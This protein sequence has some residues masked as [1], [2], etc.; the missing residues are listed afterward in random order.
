MPCWKHLSDSS[1]HGHRGYLWIQGHAC[2]C[3]CDWLHF[4]LQAN[5]CLP[6]ITEIS[7]SPLLFTQVPF[8]SPQPA[9]TKYFVQLGLSAFVLLVLTQIQAASHMQSTLCLL[10]PYSSTGPDVYFSTSTYPES[11]QCHLC[12]KKFSPCVPVQNCIYILCRVF[13]WENSLLSAL[14]PDLLFFC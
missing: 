13:I 7:K 14:N 8:Q 11:L 2:T 1:I 9:K 10:P 3:V 6:W 5:L 12:E 4:V